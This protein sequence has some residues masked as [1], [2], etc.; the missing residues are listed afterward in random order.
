MTKLTPLSDL[1]SNRNYDLSSDH[2]NV[3]GQAAYGVGGERVGTVRELLA[4]DGGQIRYVVLDVG[5]WFS[6]KEVVV[7]VGLAR[8][9][10][11]GVYFDS[12]TKEQVKGMTEY[13]AGMD[14]G[15]EAQVSD[16]RVLSGDTYQA[17]TGV[18]Q[19]TAADHYQDTA[20]FTTP[21]KLQLLEERLLVNKEKFQA[22]S[23]EVTESAERAF[24][25]DAFCT[26]TVNG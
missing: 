21:Q 25:A 22:G 9:E 26:L 10:E 6:A 23:V 8:M 3:V 17:P 18:A 12:L 16:I 15:D 14:Y 2:M 4:Q 11:D 1:V 20:M 13:T 7:P 24:H 5:G 19:P